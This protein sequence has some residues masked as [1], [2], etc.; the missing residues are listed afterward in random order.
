MMS[1]SISDEDDDRHDEAP[2]VLPQ[3]CPL[4][5]QYQY[6][7]NDDIDS[8]Y[9]SSPLSKGTL[10]WVLKSKGASTS[11]GRSDLFLRARVVQTMNDRVLVR[12]PKGS[13]Y[14]VKRSNLIPVLED[15]CLRVVIIAAETPEYRRASVVHTCVGECFLEIGCDFGPTVDRVQRALS[16]VG[17]VPRVSGKLENDDAMALVVPSSPNEERVY[18]LGV[19]KS[20]ES[21]D[22]AFSR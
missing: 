14:R 4:E 11:D 15:C 16:Q 7:L 2:L 21:I 9:F 5:K 6:V 12:Y 22:I 19:D 1:T 8:I 17:A 10:V 18:C 13:E 20:P 3:P